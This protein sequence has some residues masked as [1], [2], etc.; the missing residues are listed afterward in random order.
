MNPSKWPENPAK[1]PF[2]L[3]PFKSIEKV[4]CIK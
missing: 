3:V 4:E 2:E 1:S